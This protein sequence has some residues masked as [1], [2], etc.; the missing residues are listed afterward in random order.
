MS[1]AMTAFPSP[2]REERRVV[3]LTASSLLSEVPVHVLVSLRLPQLDM[4]IAFDVIMLA[5]NRFAAA[6]SWKISS[7]RKYGDPKI[8]DGM[9]CSS[10]FGRGGTLL[11]SSC[12]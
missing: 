5:S 4:A 2:S 11:L 10:S 3:L 9:F 6:E 1:L 8:D 7:S 12:A